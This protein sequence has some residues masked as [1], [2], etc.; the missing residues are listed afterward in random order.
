[1]ESKKRCKKGTQKYKKIGPNCYNK[2]Q[3]EEYI[4]YKKE[5]K[6]LGETKKRTQNIELVIDEK[7]SILN[8]KN[9]LLQVKR[10]KCKKG[11]IKYKKLGEGCYNKSEIDSFNELKKKIKAKLKTKTKKLRK[12]DIEF[13]I[14]DEPIN[15]ELLLEKEKEKEKEKIENN[16]TGLKTGQLV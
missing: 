14:I 7:Q 13:D 2:F 16:E 5:C 6:K 3:I 9:N 10:K 15:T 11:T 4:K 8:E 12:T 1:M